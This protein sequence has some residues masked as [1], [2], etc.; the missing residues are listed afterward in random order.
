MTR[1]VSAMLGAMAAGL[2]VQP[3]SAQD[4]EHKNPNHAEAAT[5]GQQGTM[6]DK[7]T[8]PQELYPAVRPYME[9]R[10][11]SLRTAQ[12]VGTQHH[13]GA[14]SESCDALRLQGVAEGVRILQSQNVGSNDG[15]RRE[16]LELLFGQIDEFLRPPSAEEL[17]AMI[18]SRRTA[19]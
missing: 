3:T 18:L 16:R 9:C 11:P 10:Q 17:E 5:V 15:E 6:V 4:L 7:L 2:A 19:R 12:P 14:A 13:D 1:L 8:I